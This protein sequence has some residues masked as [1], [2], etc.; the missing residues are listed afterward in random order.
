MH[1]P[2]H[3]H[4]FGAVERQ[5]L[6]RKVYLNVEFCAVIH[7]RR[8]AYTI[9]KRLKSCAKDPQEARRSDKYS[10]NSDGYGTCCTVLVF[11][12]HRRVI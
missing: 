6:A 3:T 5:L 1:S 4:A 12:G 10:P 9:K 2:E 11:G 8:A 7:P